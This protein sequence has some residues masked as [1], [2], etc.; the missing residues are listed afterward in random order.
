MLEESYKKILFKEESDV[1]PIEDFKTEGEPITL[2]EYE[3]CMTTIT[4]YVT[5]HSDSSIGRVWESIE[6]LIERHKEELFEEIPVDTD[7]LDDNEISESRAR[8][9][10]F[11][12][13]SE[14][15]GLSKIEWIWQAPDVQTARERFIKVVQETDMISQT[16]KREM[17]QNAMDK[18]TKDEMDLYAHNS[19]MSRLG[20]ASTRPR[21]F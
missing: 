4:D 7:I 9:S 12:E 21:R 19:R 14:Q 2:D 11:D 10:V 18:R 15:T 8:P 16:Q 1:Y 5:Q 3:S 13:P 17:I 20:M 6:A